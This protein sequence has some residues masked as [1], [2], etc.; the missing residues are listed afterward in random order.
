MAR[1]VSAGVKPSS[2][3]PVL[4]FDLL[5][6]P[7]DAHLEKLVQIGAGDAEELQPFEQ[8][9]AGVRAPRSTR[10]LKASQLNSRL[11]KQAVATPAL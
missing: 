6:Q 11:M 7:G 3:A 5:L 9:I 2:S 1:N 4:A 10:R 8:R